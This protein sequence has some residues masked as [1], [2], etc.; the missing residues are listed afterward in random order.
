MIKCMEL[1]N[2]YSLH[3]L[4]VTFCASFLLLFMNSLFILLDDNIFLNKIKLV[5]GIFYE[6]LTHYTAHGK[7]LWFCYFCFQQVGHCCG[8]E[9]MFKDIISN[10]LQN[11]VHLYFKLLVYYW[12]KIDW[13]VQNLPKLLNR[14]KINIKAVKNLD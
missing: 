10:Y 7:K 2:I 3:Y 13:H 1:G 4:V 14:K 11:K 6:V 8:Y 9:A 12:I 5:G